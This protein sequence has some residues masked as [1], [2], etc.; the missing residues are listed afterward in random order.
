VLELA[1]NVCLSITSISS[2]SFDARKLKIG[3]N[4]PNINGTKYT[5]QFLIFCLWPERFEVKD[6]GG[7]WFVK[8]VSSSYLSS[9]SKYEKSKRYI[10]L[11]GMRLSRSKLLSHLA[12][13]LRE[14]FEVNVKG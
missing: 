5:D 2:H 3:M 8:L 4:N 12:S 1:K 13:K 14:L 6:R 10:F 11:Q 7:D 9:Q